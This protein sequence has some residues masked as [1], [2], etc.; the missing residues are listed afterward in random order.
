MYLSYPTSRRSVLPQLFI[1][2]EGTLGV[3]TGVALALPKLSS[4]VQLACVAVESWQEVLDAFKESTNHLGEI[5]SA[6]EYYDDP[7]LELTLQHLPGAR[8][9][10]ESRTPFCAH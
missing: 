5:L 7:A 9:P 8:N 4:S 6:V 3:I 2:S 10:L 1:G